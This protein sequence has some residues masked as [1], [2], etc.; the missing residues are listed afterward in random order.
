MNEM[1]LKMLGLDTR[2]TDG[3]HE[4]QAR[5]AQRQTFKLMMAG[6]GNQDTT[7]RYTI[8]PA[9]RAL[10][11]QR[12]AQSRLT[13][14]SWLPPCFRPLATDMAFEQWLRNWVWAPL[15]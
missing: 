5:E 6:V 13:L 1:M 4:A 8:D 3:A 9:R 14:T 2:D 7:K 12:Y 10:L 15:S 11:E